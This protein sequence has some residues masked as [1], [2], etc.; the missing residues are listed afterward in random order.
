[1]IKCIRK[2]Y[3]AALLALGFISSLCVANASDKVPIPVP[4]N[5]VY[6]GQIV[7]ARLLRSRIVPLKY[8]SRVS[9][10]TTPSEVV[11]KIARTTLMPNRPIPTNY[12]IEPNAVEVNRKAI[13]RFEI[14][15][16]KITAEVIPLN[17]AKT[18]E[19][20]RARNISTGVV[21]HGIANADGSIT[22][23]VH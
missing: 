17:A 13:M 12:L 2:L 20:V 21:V 3:V 14:G 9:V 11:G 15:L 6:A 18:G 5:V 10:F 4:K 16:L 19:P 23:G 1:M 22:A 7:D 8:L